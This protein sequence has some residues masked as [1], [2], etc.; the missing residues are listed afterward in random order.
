MCTMGLQAIA[1]AVQTAQPTSALRLHS[2]KPPVRMDIRVSVSLRHVLLSN[3][4]STEQKRRVQVSKWSLCRNV[5]PGTDAQRKVRRHHPNSLQAPHFIRQECSYSRC[6]KSGV[7]RTHNRHFECKSSHTFWL[8][9]VL[10]L[11]SK[12]FYLCFSFWNSPSFDDPPNQCG[13]HSAINS[14]KWWLFLAI[15]FWYN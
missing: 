10:H 4:R 13:K 14:D 1:L 8:C 5:T 11:Q 2:R 12:W 9:L 6:F 3:L 15:Q 7:Q